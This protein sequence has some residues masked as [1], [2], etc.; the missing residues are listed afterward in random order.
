MR[1]LA[2]SVAVLMSS[3]ASAQTAR[4]AAPPVPKVSAISEQQL[5]ALIAAIKKETFGD[6]KLRA[7]E[8]V[9]PKQYFLVPQTLKILQGFAFGEDKLTAVR[10]IWPRVLDRDNAAQ[11]YQAFAFQRDKDQLAQIIG[12]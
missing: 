7:L 6:G 2:L 8:S 1:A 11:L 3:V 10:M 5:Q 9:A 4:P 12:K